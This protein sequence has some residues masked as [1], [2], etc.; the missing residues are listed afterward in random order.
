MPQYPKFQVG[1]NAEISIV[2][3]R[4]SHAKT[5]RI[6]HVIPERAHI[7]LYQRLANGISLCRES[8]FRPLS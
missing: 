2:A 1:E 8:E 4:S 7:I 3:V 5:A 6:K